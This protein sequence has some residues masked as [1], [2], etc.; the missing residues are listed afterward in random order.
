MRVCVTSQG[1]TLD[2]QIDPRFGRCNYFILADPDTMEYQ[3]HPNPA[4]DAIGGAGIQGSQ[5]VA[6]QGVQ[7]VLTG[8][9]GPNAQQV[10]AASGIKVAMDVEGTVD[11]VLEAF[12]A[13]RIVVQD[14]SAIANVSGM[15]SGRGMG[16]G[17][18]RGG[19]RGMGGGGRCLSRG[20][21][22][23]KPAYTPGPALETRAAPG[24][25]PAAPR[26]Q[27]EEIAQL[28][29]TARNIEDQLRQIQVRL[30]ELEEKQRP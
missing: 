12:K 16:G 15:G 11:E 22:P 30:R 21:W 9:L 1:N 25:T 14:V 18:G 4:R 10:F 19:S 26:T 20:N 13:G 23:A 3:A 24:R 27:Q 5:W 7:V 29:E 17:R 6:N 28:R 8:R 2:S